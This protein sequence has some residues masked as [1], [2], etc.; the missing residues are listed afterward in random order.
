MPAGRP[1]KPT[2]MHKRDG[3]FR[4]DRHAERAANSG[5]YEGFPDM[6]DD[7]ELAEQVV[8]VRIVGAMP[9]KILKSA[10]TFA[11]AT[12]CKWWVKHEVL[13]K[14]SWEYQHDPDLS[15]QFEK[16]AAKAWSICDRIFCRFGMTPADRE[17]VK[18]SSEGETR[19]TKLSRL[20]IIG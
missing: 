8:W 14:Q 2:A 19:E 9:R 16:R 15:E 1:P 4:V 12:A 20:G 10:D 11:L 7:L 17:K 18:T 3:T 5:V 6:P 13:L